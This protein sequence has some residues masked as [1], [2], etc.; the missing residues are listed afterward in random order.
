MYKV[1]I[2]SRQIILSNISEK[3]LTKITIQDTP[4]TRENLDQIIFNSTEDLTIESQQLEDLWKLFQSHFKVIV[5]AGGL[6]SKED[7]FLF[8]KRH[9]KWDI[10]KGKLEKGENE[11]EG[12]IREIEEECNIHNPKIKSKICDT[13][14]YYEFKGKQVLK[15]SIWYFLS[16]D[17]D[18]QLEPQTE[19]GITEVK[20]FSQNE[21]EE[22]RSNTYGSI[23][24]VLD[25]FE[26]M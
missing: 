9:G 20:W 24:E 8:I 4:E 14:H 15:K 19:E 25:V 1:F 12:A 6:V 10:P 18:D 26:E 21:F 2:E 5:A 17:G 7:Q 16:Y 3:K 22:I 13:Y 11:E 23:I